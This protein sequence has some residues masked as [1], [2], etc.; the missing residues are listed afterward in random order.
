MHQVIRK[1]FKYS[2]VQIRPG[3]SK[4]K[5][6]IFIVGWSFQFRDKIVNFLK[7]I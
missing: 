4:G 7:L 1:R 2:I 6:F 5:I 3:T